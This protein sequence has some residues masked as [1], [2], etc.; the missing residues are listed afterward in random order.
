[1]LRMADFQ[2]EHEPAV[3]DF[4]QWK[5]AP[6]TYRRGC[7]GPQNEINPTYTYI[8]LAKLTEHLT[9]SK[10]RDIL[11]ALFGQWDRPA[12]DAE[13]IQRH[14]LRSFAILLSAGGGRMIYHFVNYQALR[15]QY[16]PFYNEP[17]NFPKSATT[18]IF[19]TFQ[20]K[21]WQFCA[22]N[23]EYDMTDD[24]G[25]DDILPILSKEEIGDGGSATTYKITVDK[26]YSSLSPAKH[27]DSVRYSFPLHVQF[28]D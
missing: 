4:L 11:E 28:Y 22:V 20:S 5:D 6:E 26:E 10:I 23:L 25:E 9:V 7:G 17:K 8:P 24:L 15:D 12:P 16:L 18:K 3:Q 2:P 14:Y 27:D 21:Q 1:M 19:D 13:R